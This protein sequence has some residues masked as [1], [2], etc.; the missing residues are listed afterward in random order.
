VAEPMRV[1]SFKCRDEFWLWVLA[2]AARRGVTAGELIREAVE[3]LRLQGNTVPAPAV[4]AGRREGITAELLATIVD[5][6]A[7]QAE[8]PFALVSGFRVR[9]EVKARLP[10]VTDALFL[11][12]VGKMVER[13][14]LVRKGGMVGL[15]DQP[16]RTGS[17]ASS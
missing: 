14:Q 8:R 15:V 4:R 16:R 1:R 6:I 9:D 10:D 13:G 12:A 11:E 7:Q 17:R 2:E 3:G 5:E